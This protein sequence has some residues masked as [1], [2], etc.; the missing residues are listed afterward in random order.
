GPHRSMEKLRQFSPLTAAFAVLQSKTPENT[1]SH[2]G[3]PRK[4]LLPVL[5]VRALEFCYSACWGGFTIRRSPFARRPL[6]VF[7]VR[8]LEFGGS[9][10]KEPPSKD[11]LAPERT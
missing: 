7:G 8:G 1:T 3:S 9:G 11:P 10:L 2:F 5:H 6:T 4:R